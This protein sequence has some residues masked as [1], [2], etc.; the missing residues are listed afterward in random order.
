MQEGKKL[1]QTV[2]EGIIT[3]DPMMIDLTIQ[4]LKENV[5]G[6]LKDIIDTDFTEAQLHKL[7]EISAS[8]EIRNPFQNLLTRYQQERFFQEHF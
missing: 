3:D 7:E 8:L 1:T 2:T 6:R 4:C 5:Y